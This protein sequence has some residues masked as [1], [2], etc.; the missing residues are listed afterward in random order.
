MGT[1]TFRSL[2]NRLH[3][4]KIWNK[5]ISNYSQLFENRVISDYL[6]SSNSERKRWLH[7]PVKNPTAYFRQL[8]AQIDGVL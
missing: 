5:E 8:I 7:Q 1:Q 4:N 3:N 2:A 6:S